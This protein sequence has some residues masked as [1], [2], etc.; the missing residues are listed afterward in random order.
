M[1]W[2]TL[3][4]QSAQQFERYF[5]YF[6]EDDTAFV[7]PDASP[8]SVPPNVLPSQHDSDRLAQDHDYP[9]AVRHLDE[10]DDV[11]PTITRGLLDVPTDQAKAFLETSN[12]AVE[13]TAVDVSEA[14][15][16]VNG[17]AVS[18]VLTF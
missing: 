12:A 2:N 1:A 10:D 4:F 3:E 7:A 8:H 17:L 13:S 14:H 11:L 16:S 15:D 18:I 9:E 6:L 5:D